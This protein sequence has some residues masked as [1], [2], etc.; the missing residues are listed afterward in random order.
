MTVRLPTRSRPA[1]TLC[2]RLLFAATCV[3]LS[4]S[5]P[6][7]AR[8]ETASGEILRVRVHSKWEGLGRARDD[9]IVIERRRRGFF[10]GGARIDGAKIDRLR[11]ALAAPP[12][13]RPILP[14][15][16]LSR[17]W[18]AENAEDALRE[19]TD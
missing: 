8:Q 7:V 13:A 2:G 18:L 15:L 11:A 17:Q 6:A 4:W 14:S 12:L 3:L 16:G 10:S 1:A 5:G 19:E 9:E